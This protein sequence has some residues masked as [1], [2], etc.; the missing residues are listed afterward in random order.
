[1]EKG[2]GNYLVSRR[3]PENLTRCHELQTYQV[4]RMSRKTPAFWTPIS[5]SSG[6][7]PTHNGK[8]DTPSPHSTPSV[9]SAPRSQRL[10]RFDL[11]AFSV[12]VTASKASKLVSR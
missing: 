2:A 9:P 6:P 11:E 12:S 8:G 10:W 4:S 3:L 1:M 5:R 7:S